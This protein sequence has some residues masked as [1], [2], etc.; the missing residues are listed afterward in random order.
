MKRYKV[1]FDI[2]AIEKA[3]IETNTSV[4]AEDN[5]DFKNKVYTK[6]YTDFCINIINQFKNKLDFKEY[7]TIAKGKKLFVM[8]IDVPITSNLKRKCDRIKRA[9]IAIEKPVEVVKEEY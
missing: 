8:A 5:I 9:P 3:F 2:E 7:E 6:M 4:K 1:A